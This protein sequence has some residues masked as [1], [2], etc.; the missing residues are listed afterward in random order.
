[1]SSSSAGLVVCAFDGLT[2]R[3]FDGD[4]LTQ[5]DRLGEGLIPSDSDTDGDVL[6]SEGRTGFLS[7]QADTETAKPAEASRAS[8]AEDFLTPTH[9]GHSHRTAGPGC[10]I[11]TEGPQAARTGRSPRVAGSEPR[12]PAGATQSLVGS[13]AR[14][15]HQRYPASSRLVHRPQV[16]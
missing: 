4:G 13:Q 9:I 6:T 11:V 2:V 16:P 7:L 3:C 10:H 1:M 14:P 8:T 12:A 5:C 15:H